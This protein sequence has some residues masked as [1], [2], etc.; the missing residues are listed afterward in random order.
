MEVLIFVFLLVPIFGVIGIIR[1]A[2]KP[3]KTLREWLII[4]ILAFLTLLDIW[5]VSTIVL[6]TKTL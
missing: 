5:I 1:Q 3:K 6:F 2:K 4:S